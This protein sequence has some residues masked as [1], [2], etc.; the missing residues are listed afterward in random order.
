MTRLAVIP[1]AFTMIVALF[2]V[3]GA[4]PWKVKELAAMYLPVYAVIFVTGPGEFSLD[5]K[6][7][8]KA[9]AEPE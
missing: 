2:V 6:L 1:L 5:K 7:F 9:T 8:G 4:D 3:H